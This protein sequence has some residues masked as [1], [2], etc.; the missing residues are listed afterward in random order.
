MAI[1]DLQQSKKQTYDFIADFPAE[2][3]YRRT[4]EALALY[5][6]PVVRFKRDRRTDEL[7]ERRKGGL[8]WYIDNDNPYDWKMLENPEPLEHA[9]NLR[10]FAKGWMFFEYATPAMF[11]ASVE[12]VIR[13]IP[14]KYFGRV[15]AFEIGAAQYP[16][17]NGFCPMQSHAEHDG[18][19]CAQTT[20]Y[21]H[22][23]SIPD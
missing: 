15:I 21:E 12:E 13:Q 7:Q 4:L 22:D 8:L 1:T 3:M 14:P 6:R 23:R 11:R 10:A 19:H 20:L 9:R 5:I 2:K 17:G 18:H 16:L